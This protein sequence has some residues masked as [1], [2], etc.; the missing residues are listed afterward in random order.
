MMEDTARTG[1]G[2][3]RCHGPCGKLGQH[4]GSRTGYD[5]CTLAHDPSCPGDVL[6]VTGKIASCP[7]GY[8]PGMSFPESAVTVLPER[9][10]SHHTQGGRFW[11]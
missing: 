5:F 6:E 9:E 3:K 10:S 2:C 1:I 8:L 7:V 4:Q 11:K